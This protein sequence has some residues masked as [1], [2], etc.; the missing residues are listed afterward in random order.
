MK[1]ARFAEEQ[2][3]FALRHSETGT[4]IGRGLPEDGY[5]GGDIL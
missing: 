5:L 2:I 4:K 3:A 1:T